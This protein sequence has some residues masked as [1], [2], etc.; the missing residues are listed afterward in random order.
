MRER[1]ANGEARDEAELVV[2][3]GFSRARATKLLDPLLL[4]P[5]IQESLPHMAVE[6]GRR[7]TFASGTC[8]G[9]CRHWTGA[10]SER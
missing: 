2:S 1:I 8:V 10:S 3:L 7:D 4:A 6:V 9:W 5:D